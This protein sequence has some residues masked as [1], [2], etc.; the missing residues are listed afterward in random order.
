MI[1]YPHLLFLS[2]V[3]RRAGAPV[4][5]S[6]ARTSSRPF[7]TSNIWCKGLDLVVVKV[8]VRRGKDGGIEVTDIKVEDFGSFGGVLSADKSE[9]KHDCKS[10][11]PDEFFIERDLLQTKYPTHSK[12]LM[13][14]PPKVLGQPLDPEGH[15]ECILY[16]LAKARV[17]ND[18]DYPAAVPK[19]SGNSQSYVVKPMGDMGLG[20]FATR[21]IEAG[22]ITLA[23]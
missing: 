13:T 3:F 22:D 7:G 5:S 9:E 1:R 16:G 6:I 14:I 23:E 12:V 2:P 21:D 8:N 19:P 20:A 11:E 15:S 4:K 18:P 17:V 10:P